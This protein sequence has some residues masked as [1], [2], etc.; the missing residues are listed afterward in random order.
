MATK[1]GLFDDGK[2]DINAPPSYDA[3]STTSALSGYSIQSNSPPVFSSLQIKQARTTVLSLIS[4]IVST[5]DFIP[6]SVAPIV[7]SCAATLPVSEFSDLLQTPNIQGHTAMYW[8]VVNNRQEAL[9]VFSGFIPKL[10]STCSSDLRLACTITSDQA[11]F[12]QLDLG[13]TYYGKC[14]V[15]PTR[16]RINCGVPTSHGPAFETFFGL[17]TRSD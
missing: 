5:P 2:Y 17:S 7:N 3:I 15:M 1:V 10:S 12:M 14:M 6:S 11:L 16:K 4:D 8:A 13:G 9:S